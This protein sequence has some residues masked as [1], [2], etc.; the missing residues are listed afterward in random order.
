MKSA[1]I[2]SCRRIVASS[3]IAIG[4][5][6]SVCTPSS[7]YAAQQDGLEI[8]RET[9]KAFASLA[10][11]TTPA[12]VYIETSLSPSKEGGNLLE[13]PLDFFNDDFFNRF[14]GGSVPENK[15]KAKKEHAFGSGF[16]VS[17]DGYVLTNHHL[18][19]D[20]ESVTVTL[21]G[22]RKLPAKIIGVDPKTDI[23]VIKVDAKDLPY[24]VLGDSSSLEVGEWVM[25]IGNPFGL[26]ASV[27][28]G[29]VSAK[30]RSQL[31][32]TDFEDFI[33]T[34]AAINP[35]NSGGPL[36]NMDGKVIG[37]N[38]AIVSPGGGG[39]V[40]IGFAVPSNM[41]KPIMG[42]LIKTGKV[43]RGFLG[44][45]LQQIDGDLASSFGLS[46][47]EGA[48]ISDITKG[49]PA[50]SAGLKS[51]DV[52]LKYNDSPVVNISQ[53]RNKVSLMSP[54]TNLQLS[55]Y[56]DGKMILI[57]VQVGMQSDKPE[58]VKQAIP[59]EHLGLTVQDVT[60]ELAKRYG[61]E[62][63]Q[64]VIVTKVQPGSLGDQSGIKPGAL[65][66]AIDRKKVA[67]T[68][69]FEQGV[70]AAI[71]SKRIL[72]LVKQGAA[73]RYIALKF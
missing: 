18:V 6:A 47:P 62:S 68:D 58:K 51:G 54:G 17:A 13:N 36:L 61:Y 31:H 70:L 11:K 52:I 37:M 46:K 72:L 64:G 33:Q 42:Q 22:D 8:L 34:D 40:G 69:D 15:P 67:S 7:C 41:I 4:C 66:I 10:K 20:A 60:P 49:S 14:F 32:L 24:A 16:I 3:F 39:Y 30:D 71:K 65:I 63:D 55:V 38:T 12:V 25:A 35:G 53:F 59:A 43:T 19:K 9:S 45:A 23:A 26:E 5:M 21:Q 29:V 56:R 1:F 48:L 50:E 57:P 28:V 2:F 73:T 27:T 44:I